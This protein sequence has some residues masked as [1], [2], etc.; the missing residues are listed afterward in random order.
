MRFSALRLGACGPGRVPEG[1]VW[2]EKIPGRLD[3]LNHTTHYDYTIRQTHTTY[4]NGWLSADN[5]NNT[6]QRGEGEVCN[7]VQHLQDS[8]IEGKEAGAL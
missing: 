4:D 1:G 5:A 3:A 2:R 8:I 7:P 6:N